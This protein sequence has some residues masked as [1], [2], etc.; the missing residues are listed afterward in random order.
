[1]FMRQIYRRLRWGR[2]IVI[3]SGLPRSGT[4][5]MMRMLE[6][7]GVPLMTDDVRGAD[8][9]NLRGYFELAAV[10]D[11]GT[12]ADRRWLSAARGKALKVVSPL[13]EH[14]P[15]TCNY[16]VLFML[17]DLDEVIASQNRMLAL[18][19]E[20]AGATA[21]LR[22][23]YRNHVQRVL[24]LVDRRSGFVTL[25]VE[26]ADVLRRPVDEASRIQA[27]LHRRLDVPAMAAAVDEELYR[28]RKEPRPRTSSVT[29]SVRRTNEPGA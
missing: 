4:S 8:E 9:S 7:G 25:L 11:L 28:N 17:R 14:L 18:A 23:Q 5:M 6:A 3:V 10:K 26:Y 19:G 16:Q 22:A 1:M 13:V 21:H 27:F 24:R 15:P 2:P 20:P 29:S 12:S